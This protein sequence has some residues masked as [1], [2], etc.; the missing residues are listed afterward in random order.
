MLNKKF[1]LEEFFYYLRFF[2][3]NHIN[4]KINIYN[5]CLLVILDYK[6]KKKKK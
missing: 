2:I 6:C 3:I 1:I 5:I 4:I